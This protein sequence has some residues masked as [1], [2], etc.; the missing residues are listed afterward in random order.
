MC[1]MNRVLMSMVLIM[2]TILG[3]GVSAI[4]VYDPNS[5]PYANTFGT[6]MEF[7]WTQRK[8][9]FENGRTQTIDALRIL[10]NI[11]Y[12]IVDQ[13][14]IYVKSGLFQVDTLEGERANWSFGIGIGARGWIAEFQNG[15][16]RIGLD[17]QIF[18]S[19]LD[20]SSFTIEDH[21]NYDEDITWTEYQL[22]GVVSWRAYT[23]LNLYTGVQISAATI[24][25]ETR[26]YY[27]LTD[28]IVR[29]KISADQDQ[30][31]ALLWGITYEITENIHA[32]GELR[33]LSEVS[34]AFG[35][36]IYF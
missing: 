31:I 6:G 15:D 7:D 26:K 29:E 23:P 16:V 36:Q 10:A 12:S 22:S 4:T 1:V 9:D 25:Y 3:S 14:G 33:A 18:R 34:G 5:L 8:F 35:L 19:Q 11:N 30:E 21:Y 27:W 28:E 20:Y 32:Y 2:I 17:G 24:D 13:F